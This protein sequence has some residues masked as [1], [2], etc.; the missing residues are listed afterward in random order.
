MD[1]HFLK[2]ALWS[3]YWHFN[4]HVT[5]DT[6]LENS[7]LLDCQI[8]PSHQVSFGNSFCDSEYFHLF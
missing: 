7:S 3:K 4:M 6:F 5:L 2:V 8:Y 1:F